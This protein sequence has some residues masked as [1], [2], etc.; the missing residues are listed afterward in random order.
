MAEVQHAGGRATF[1]WL[2]ADLK[3][4]VYLSLGWSSTQGAELY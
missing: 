3:M 1:D 2:E 4:A